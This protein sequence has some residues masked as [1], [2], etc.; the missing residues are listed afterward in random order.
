LRGVIGLSSFGALIYYAIA[1]PAAATL[2]DAGRWA[3]VRDACGLLGC[4]VLVATLPAESL[5]AGCGVFAVGIAGR[6]FR[7]RPRG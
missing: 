7:A 6:A 5:I 4:L 2:P 3:R 1:N